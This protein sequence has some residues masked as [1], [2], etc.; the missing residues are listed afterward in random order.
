[1]F[2]HLNSHSLRTPCDGKKVA[3]D[4]ELRW[5]EEKQCFLQL[6]KT[7]VRAPSFTAHAFHKHVCLTG[8]FFLPSSDTDGLGENYPDFCPGKG[9][10]ALVQYVM[11]VYVLCVNKTQQCKLN[12]VF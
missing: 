12:S 2:H 6:E 10:F 9:W 7:T 4:R 11:H 1:M 3:R 5:R 8:V